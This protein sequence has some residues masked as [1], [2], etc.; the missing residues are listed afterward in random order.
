MREGG[1]EGEGNKRGEGECAKKRL[2]DIG[3]AK[4]I[5][6]RGRGSLL[7]GKGKRKKGNDKTLEM[8][9]RWTGG[10]QRGKNTRN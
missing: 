2:T 8:Q 6:K 7:F 1:Q 9:K 10:R 5:E 4:N 3:R